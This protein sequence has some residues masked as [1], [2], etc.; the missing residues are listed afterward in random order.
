VR[1][2]KTALAAPLAVALAIPAFA[3][4]QPDENAQ[5]SGNAY[6]VICQR[7]P[8]VTKP[9]TPAFKACIAQHR[10][11]VNGQ[12]SARA[13]ALATCRISFEPDERNTEGFRNCVASTRTLILGLRGLKAQS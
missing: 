3:I 4:G 10:Q 9:G 6:G 7:A 2:P 5:P 8:N 1:I 11:G 12:K 13:A